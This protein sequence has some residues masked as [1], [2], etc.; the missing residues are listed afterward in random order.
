[1][2]MQ[3]KSKI[4]NNLSLNVKQMNKPTYLIYVELVTKLQKASLCYSNEWKGSLLS[5]R[6]RI[7]NQ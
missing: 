6:I 7:T 3:Y 1:M 5:E 4:S 2:L